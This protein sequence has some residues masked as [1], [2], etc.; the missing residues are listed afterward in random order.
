ML[1]LSQ[2]IIISTIFFNMGN[3]KKCFLSSK[4]AHYNDFWRIMWHWR[5]EYCCW[6]SALI[7]EINYI[8][9][10]INIENSYSNC[11]NFSQ[12]YRIF[13]QIN[14]ACYKNIHKCYK[15]K[16]VVLN[17]TSKFRH[18]HNID[19]Y[20]ELYSFDSFNSNICTFKWNSIQMLQTSA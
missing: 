13:I 20:E 9:K 6:N 15:L 4:S 7:T 11:K 10:Y 2:K 1:F 12:Y 19:S 14:A 3:N 17:A 5:L 16:S 18:H 8:L